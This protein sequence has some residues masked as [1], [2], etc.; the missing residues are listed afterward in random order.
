MEIHIRFC[1]EPI[2]RTQVHP[3]QKEE[4]GAR[5]EFYGTVR[6]T[7]AG[8]RIRGL[9]Y[10]IYE[11]MGERQIRKLLGELAAEH[12]CTAVSV[13][14]RQG[15][16]LAGETAIYV[17]ITATHR[18]EAFGMLASLMDRIKQDVPIWKTEVL[19]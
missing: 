5:V 4:D 11:P 1:R 15:A 17:G 14:H 12:Q 13:L 6:A 8:E 9:L 19:R 18:K 2:T 16:V 10:E 3:A 7:E